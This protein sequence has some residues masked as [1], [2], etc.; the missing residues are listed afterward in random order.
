MLSFICLCVIQIFKPYAMI[1]SDVPSSIAF[2]QR[3]FFTFFTYKS[4]HQLIYQQCSDTANLI[5]F[6]FFPAHF[7]PTENAWRKDTF[8]NGKF[9]S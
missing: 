2:Y 7:P 9:P 4:V 1:F 5:F 6:L 8:D 3:Y